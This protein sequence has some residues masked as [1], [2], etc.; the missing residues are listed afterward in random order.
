[1]SSNQLSHDE[2]IVAEGLGQL[3]QVRKG[4][5]NIEGLVKAYLNR[6]QDLE[7]TLWDI[8]NDRL[9]ATATNAQLDSL[10]A[11]VDEDRLG[12]NDTDYRLAIQVQ[13]RVLRTH[14]RDFDIIAVALLMGFVFTYL[15]QYPAGWEVDQYGVGT[16]ATWAALK[17]KNTKAAGTA[18]V[19]AYSP[20]TKVNTFV[21]GSTHGGVII[22]V[23]GGGFSS[24]YGGTTKQ[25]KLGGVINV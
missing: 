19:Y 22:G 18:G 16:F 21:F 12:R 17:F 7:D 14:G 1:M 25:G 20:E 6:C 13:I 15:E 24:A 23:G 11:L 5:L 4:L 10:G 8:I 9:L 3:G 2:S